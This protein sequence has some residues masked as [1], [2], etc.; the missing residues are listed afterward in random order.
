V[1]HSFIGYSS[2]GY[3]DGSFP[4]AGLIADKEDALYGTT[5][6]GGNRD[7]GM[8]FRLTPPATGQTAWTETALYSFTGGSDGF[9][10]GAGLIADKQGALYGTT[11]FGGTGYGTVFRLTPPTRGQKTWTETVLYSFIGGSD[12]GNPVAGLIF[13]KEGALYSTTLQ[14]GSSNGG[15]VFKLTPPAKGQTAWTETVLYSFCSLSSCS[16]G[17]RPFA[18]LIAD[19][20]DALYSTTIENG[21]GDYGTV[22][23][24]TPP[25]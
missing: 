9:N 5:Y 20:E 25:A 3:S 13:D 15:T 22:F 7:A 4:F 17:L 16:D 10:P 1:L 18:G 11:Q 24:L 23:R 8:V 2:T 6:Q 19:K 14:G 21:S 12:G